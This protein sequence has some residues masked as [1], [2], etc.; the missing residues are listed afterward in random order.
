MPQDHPRLPIFVLFIVFEIRA[1]YFFFRF[2]LNLTSF[3]EANIEVE[4]I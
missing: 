4:W 3:Q 2:R 1:F